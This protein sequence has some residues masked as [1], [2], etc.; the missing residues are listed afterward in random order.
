MSTTRERLLRAIERIGKTEVERSIKL[1][2]TVRAIDNWYAGSGL[3]T[4]EK[5]IEAGVLIINDEAKPAD[6][7]TA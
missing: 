4:V 3:K 7:I 2:V 5:L 6:S 1:A